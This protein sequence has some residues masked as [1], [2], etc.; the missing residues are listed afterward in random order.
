MTHLVADP[1]VVGHSQPGVGF[2]R[3][4][5]ETLL[6]WDA[7]YRERL[8]LRDLPEER[9]RDLGMTRPDVARETSRPIWRD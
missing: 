9:L 2:G 6:V 8:R 1:V 3:R 4:L 5:L 7:R